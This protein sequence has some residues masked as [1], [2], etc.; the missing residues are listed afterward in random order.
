[1]D[2]DSSTV[3]NTGDLVTI[4]ITQKDRNIFQR[5][6]SMMIG[7]SYNNMEVRLTGMVR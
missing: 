5:I 6:S 3:W 2:L 1:M 7:M 4:V